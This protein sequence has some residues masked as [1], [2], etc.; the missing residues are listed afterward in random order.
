MWTLQG[1]VSDGASE[2]GDVSWLLGSQFMAFLLGLPGDSY[3]S[4]LTKRIANL[5]VFT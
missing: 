5:C 3:L 1:L 4:A 2:A